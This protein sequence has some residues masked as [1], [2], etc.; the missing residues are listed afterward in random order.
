MN[1]PILCAAARFG[2]F[3]R[4]LCLGALLGGMQAATA[5]TQPTFTVTAKEDAPD[6]E[7]SDGLCKST[8]PGGPCTLRA[9]V[10]ENN[11]NPDWGVINLPANI[12]QLDLGPLTIS[13]STSIQGDDASTT[14]IAANGKK[15]FVI[16]GTGPFNAFFSNLTI[17]NARD[18]NDMRNGHGAA[19]DY[20]SP[21]AS[22]LYRVDFYG[23]STDWQGGAIA[24]A[25]ADI[26]M[27]ECRMSNNTVP[28]S[29][30]S[31]QTGSGG[32]IANNGVMRIY[33]S[34][35]TGNQGTRGGA[36]SNSGS[37][38]VFNSTFTQNSV[39][40][41]GGAIYNSF[42]TDGTTP[43]QVTLAFD[44]FYKNVAGTE[45]DPDRNPSNRDFPGGGALF[46]A[47]DMFVGNCILSG[48]VD[49]R[50]GSS[51]QHIYS[52]DVFSRNHQVLIATPGGGI[53]LL[54][55][56]PRFTSFRGNVFGTVNPAVWNA[57]DAVWGDLRFDQVGFDDPMLASLRANGGHTETFAPLPRSPA[58]EQG[59]GSTSARIFDCPATDQR[60][61]PRPPHSGGPNGERCD[62]GAY[63]VTPTSGPLE[64][65]NAELFGAFAIVSDAQASGGKFVAAPNGTGD[66]TNAPDEAQRMRFNV[67]VD[68]SG[69]YNLKGWCRGTG[70][71]D[72]SFWVKLDGLPAPGNLWDF[73]EGSAQFAERLVTH[74]GT[75]T[76]DAPEVNPVRFTLFKGMHTVDVYLREDGAQLDR[77]QILPAVQ[78]SQNLEVESSSMLSGA[79]MVGK[80]PLA[81]AGKYVFT[82]ATYS[83]PANLPDDTHKVTTV[84][85]VTQAG[86][87]LVRANVHASFD[88]RNSFWVKVDGQPSAGYVWD[89]TETNTAYGL[90][91]VS[92]RGGG[93]SG[94][95]DQDPVELQLAA[96][97]HTI[98]VFAREGGTRLD[99][100]GLEPKQD[101]D[102]RIVSR[103]RPA[104][105]SSSESSSLTAGKAVDG[106]QGTRWAS[107]AG[108]DQWLRVD[109]QARY[110]IDRVMLYWD[111]A[112]GKE[113]E[114]QISE[115]GNTWT[116]L[117][118][119]A[120]G[121]GGGDNLMVDG[122]G[123]YVRM[124]GVKRGTSGGYSLKE[125]D[126]YGTAVTSG[127]VCQG[128]CL[129][130]QPVSRYQNAVFN[131]TGERWFVVKDIVTGW[132]ASEI[133]GR[134]ISVNGIAVSAGQMPLPPRVNGKY[135]F[136]F[137]P[138]TYSWA[139]WSFWN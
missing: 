112:Y 120:E 103:N 111:A 77:I 114:I 13:S 127:F 37:L 21:V 58:L 43:Y 5:Q 91:Y 1:L 136:Q 24:N 6:A 47:G 29:D 105:A 25:G 137:S 125:F 135:Y 11:R 40:F 80:D 87:Y 66:R 7:A 19:L 57:A 16:A 48:N 54:D 118:H 4:F 50:V 97:A 108:D 64:A 123:R 30:G 46:N 134:T 106:N 22:G 36:I 121:N 31:G 96:G 79:F 133:A 10:E 51:W 83:N 69:D 3:A 126:V 74:R 90:D 49:S 18:A 81:S 33:R 110:R 15:A 107:Q 89:M 20:Q 95:P 61:V 17:A 56:F 53:A 32:A 131:T 62:V 84:V 92:H 124:K 109:L 41:Q 59:V 35:F 138:G 12:Y 78:F 101:A 76:E 65:E 28:R 42:K 27:Q 132:Q 14:Q 129:S 52:P 75:G 71:P 9:A 82:P 88:D 60:G 72:N 117:Y 86:T 70:V 34:T 98:E 68:E 115:D 93:N 116:A 73:P 100:I 67:Y 139:A 122:T 44:T 102:A 55:L 99:R 38:E 63:E 23:N 128:G 119:K 104:T 45:S 94:N 113:Y 130:A 8:L 85:T 39:D 2:A 26:T